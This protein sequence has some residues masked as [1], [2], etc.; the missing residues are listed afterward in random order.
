MMKIKNKKAISTTMV[1]SVLFL[2]H[3]LFA[4]KIREIRKSLKKKGIIQ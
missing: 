2:I 1:S 4:N 3:N